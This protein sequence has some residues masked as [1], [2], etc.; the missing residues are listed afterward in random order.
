METENKF[1]PLNFAYFQESIKFLTEA[2]G[3]AEIDLVCS[4]NQQDYNLAKSLVSDPS[5]SNFSEAFNGFLMHEQSFVPVSRGHLK[6]ELYKPET[7]R[8]H[9]VKKAKEVDLKRTEIKLKSKQQPLQQQGEIQQ[10]WESP[11]DFNEQD[12]FSLPE[13]IEVELNRQLEMGFDEQFGFDFDKQIGFNFGEQTGLSFYQQIGLDFEQSG[14]KFNQQV[15]IGLGYPQQ[16]DFQSSPQNDES[17]LGSF[18]KD[19]E[20]L[21]VLKKS[22]HIPKQLKKQKEA[23]LKRIVIGDNYKIKLIGK[24]FT[25]YNECTYGVPLTSVCKEN[26][27]RKFGEKGLK[28]ALADQ[29]L[30]EIDEMFGS[31]LDE[32]DDLFDDKY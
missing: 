26:F 20:Y 18:N 29:N 2:C 12:L 19:P 13:Q 17:L 32:F 9:K 24:Y 8:V 15:E 22:N 4:Y 23:N 1:I 30:K 25:E 10:P 14:L 28:A 7:K 16:N 6:S 21:E 5:T 3:G 11:Y 27:I 31:D